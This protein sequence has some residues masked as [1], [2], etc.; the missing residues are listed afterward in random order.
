MTFRKLMFGKILLGLLGVSI[1]SSLV[2]AEMDSGLP[3]VEVEDIADGNADGII[4]YDGSGIATEQT[5]HGVRAVH[6]SSQTISNSTL[7]ILD[8]NAEQ[9]DDD[10]MHDNVTNNSRLT[11]TVAGRYVINTQVRWANNS[12]GHRILDILLNGT[13]LIARHQM[14]ANTA[15][16]TVVTIATIYDLALDDYVETRV[17]QSSGGNLDVERIASHA[18]EFM[19]QQVRN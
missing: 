13:T 9:F 11:A 3:A 2:G 1:A 6:G 19:M 17:F 8:Y 16:A 14:S 12:T 4:G 15:G 5:R 18:P 7:T 10:D